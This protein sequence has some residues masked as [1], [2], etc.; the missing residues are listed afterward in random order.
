[1]G[2]RVVLTKGL[3]GCG[4]ST[5]AREYSEKSKSVWIIVNRDSLRRMMHPADNV[6]GYRF[7][8][9]NERIVTKTRDYVIL[10]ALDAG[11]N[12]IVDETNLNPKNVRHLEQ[13]LSDKTTATVETVSFID[14]PLDVCLE[15]NL[16]RRWSVP[17]KVIKD[18]H[19]KYIAEGAK[20]YE[21]N[22]SLR[23]CVVF[24]LDG[25]LAIMGDRSPYS[26]E[27]HLDT[28][29]QEVYQALKQNIEAGY[30]IVLLSGRSSDYRDETVAWLEAND[31]PYDG[32]YMR[33]SGDMRKD[34]IIK[35]ELLEEF[36]LP[37]CN[38]HVIYDDRD[39]VVE[40]W[41]QYGLTCFQVAP[42]A[43]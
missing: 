19:A 39:Q 38:V 32:L 37:N 22:P 5:W 24:D 34:S 16:M 3:P 4:K 29:N 31:V 30:I 20:K 41:R 9:L 23:G 8:K 33:K 12:V 18:M 7:S 10:Q 17:D 42:G 11:R 2:Q 1:M 15:R 43:F 6:A 35:I 36:V 14:T 25:T 40:A 28:L 27:Y 26:G 21:K 13:M